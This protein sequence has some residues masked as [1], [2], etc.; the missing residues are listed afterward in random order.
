[1]I[2]LKYTIVNERSCF[3]HIRNNRGLFFKRKYHSVYRKVILS[4]MTWRM[5]VV[6]P[7]QKGLVLRMTNERKV[8]LPPT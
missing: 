4:V 6:V 7:V 8:P 1:M 5:D 3:K 2:N